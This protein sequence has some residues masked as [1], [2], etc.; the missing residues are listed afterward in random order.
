MDGGRSIE[1]LVQLKR[2]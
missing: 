2:G 1:A